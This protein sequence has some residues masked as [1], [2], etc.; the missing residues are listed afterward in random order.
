MKSKIMKNHKAAKKYKETGKLLEATGFNTRFV[1]LYSYYFKKDLAGWHNHLVLKTYGDL[2]SKH[3]QNTA[4]I[5]IKTYDGDLELTY[6]DRYK[7]L[8][9]LKID[10]CIAADIKLALDTLHHLTDKKLF[11]ANKIKRSKK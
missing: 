9:T 7:K 2:W 5:D 8:Q 6:L 11:A 3:M 4:I 1:E 10:I